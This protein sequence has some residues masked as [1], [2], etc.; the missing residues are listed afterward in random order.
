MSRSLRADTRSRAKDD[1][2]R[3]MQAIDKVRKWEKKW[4][5]IG[6]TSMKIFK[7]VPVTS[8]QSFAAKTAA[9][10]SKVSSA[11]SSVSGGTSSSSSGA[12]SASS[13]YTGGNNKE[14]I[15][16][17]STGSSVKMTAS[18]TGQTIGSSSTSVKDVSQSNINDNNR[19]INM[20]SVGN[21]SNSSS[22]VVPPTEDSS[23]MG[24]SAS[25]SSLEGLTNSSTGIG[26][27]GNSHQ[28]GNGM[29]AGGGSSE[30]GREGDAGLHHHH[31]Q[32]STP[33]SS[34][35]MTEDNSSDAQFPDSISRSSNG[36]AEPP[37]KKMKL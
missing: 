1:L 15:L 23:A 26:V 30:G 9:A 33:S 13:S 20:T 37:A 28:E 17:S 11:P 24:Y 6:E 10:A 3:A 34:L 16:K 21:N 36:S 14:N 7:W 4:V 32:S 31:H 29:E 8:S 22:Y 18:S 5:T 19:S 2:K 35:L 25:E 12:G 27:G